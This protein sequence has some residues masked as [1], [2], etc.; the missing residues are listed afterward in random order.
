[1][2]D[3]DDILE[4]SVPV[5]FPELHE[6]CGICGEP[7]YYVN[8]LLTEACINPDCAYGVDLSIELN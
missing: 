3:Y 2:K 8:E 7:L 5:C 6:P 1:M 4:Y